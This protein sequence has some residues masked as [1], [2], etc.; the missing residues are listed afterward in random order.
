M[1][2][3]NGYGSVVKLSGTRR[4]PYAVKVSYWE[5]EPGRQPKRRQKYLGYFSDKK[6][7]LAYLAEYNSGNVVKEHIPYTNVLTFA[8][9]Y[10]KWK[11]YRKSL[12]NAPGEASWKNYGIAFGFFA[13][14][15]DKKITNIK[16][17]DLQDCISAKS[18]KSKSTIGNMRALVNGMWNYALMNEYVDKN[19]TERLVY[20]YTMTGA[21]VHTR[22]LDS[23]ISA[24]WDALWTIPNVDIV[25]IYIYTGMRP[26]ELLNITVEDVHLDEWNENRGWQKPDHP[27]P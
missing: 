2:L 12:K 4:R 21:P 18:S 6:A 11:S 27:S 1:K 5:A 26:S 10:E 9:L 15:H 3:P 25:L 17:Q 20:E 22:F 8:E 19:I 24:L 16:P 14:V 7:A 13:A 23:E